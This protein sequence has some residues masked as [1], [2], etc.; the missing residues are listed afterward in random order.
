MADPD[1]ESSA[2]LADELATVGIERFTARDYRPGT[3]THIVL[4]R[5]TDAATASQ[6]T[7]VAQRFAALAG[8]ERDGAAYIR[9]ITHGAQASGEVGRSPDGPAGFDHGFVVLFDSLGD[10]NYYVGEPVIDDP[11]FFDAVHAEFKRFVGPL[12]ADVAV[13]DFVS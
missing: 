8:T 9:S 4:F 3:V 1:A 2:Q 12:L 7:E 10:R 5:Y 11:A 6:R 13:L